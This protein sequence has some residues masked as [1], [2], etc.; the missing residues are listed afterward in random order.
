MNVDGPS[1]FELPMFPLGSVTVPGWLLPL[2]VFEPRYRELVARC[3]STD[4]RFG[5][6]LIERGSEVGGGDVRCAIGCG[7]TIVDA[8]PEP[9]GRWA[10]FAVGTMRIRVVQW[11]E[12]DPY[13]RALVEVLEEAPAG[14][15]TAELLEDAA[16]AVHSFLLRAREL[17]VSTVDPEIELSDDP[18]HA[19]HMMS[20]LAPLG[21]LDR[22]ALLAS[23]GP[24][25]RLRLLL[26]LMDGRIEMLE[27]RFGA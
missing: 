10:V 3:L 20:V 5:T 6:V 9:D 24:T 2:Q 15:G 27:A 11:L 21:P 1:P 13:P 14:A 16:T 8:T 4:R 19:S 7:V 17:G 18:V 12:D 26:E 22:Q 25:E 23:A